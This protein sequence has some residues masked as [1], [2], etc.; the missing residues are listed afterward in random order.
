MALGDTTFAL[1]HVSSGGPSACFF[2]VAL[3][4]A[5]MVS[6]HV[7]PSQYSADSLPGTPHRSL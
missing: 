5:L 2:P 7:C 6:M 4:L 3:A 1:P